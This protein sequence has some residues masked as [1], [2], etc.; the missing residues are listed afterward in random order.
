MTMAGS[1]KPETHFGALVREYRLA[2][3]MTQPELADLLKLGKT[4][5]MD[6]EIGPPRARTVEQVLN[7]AFFLD[8]PFDVLVAALKADG[9]YLPFPTGDGDTPPD[10]VKLAAEARHLSEEDRHFLL[11]QIRLLRRRQSPGPPPGTPPAEPP[12]SAQ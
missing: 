5:V 3:N 6:M 7:L 11:E 12:V 2:R 4:T 8:V 1:K 10:L 9:A